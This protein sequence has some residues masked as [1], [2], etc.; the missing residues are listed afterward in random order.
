MVVLGDTIGVTGIRLTDPNAT[1]TMVWA[2]ESSLPDTPTGEEG[3]VWQI[4]VNGVPVDSGFQGQRSISQP[5]FSD[6]QS[7]LPASR[8]GMAP[9]ECYAKTL[10]AGDYGAGVVT[11]QA[12]AFAH[13]GVSVKAMRPIA[14][15]NDSDGTDRRPS[16]KTIHWRAQTGSNSN[17]GLSSGA[18]VKDL[19]KAIELACVS[20]NCGGATIVMHE[21]HLGGGGPVSPGPWHTGALHYLTIQCEPGTTWSRVAAPISTYPDDYVSCTGVGS[22]T[23]CR[24]RIQNYHVVGGGP[25]FA[26]NVNGSGLPDVVVQMWREGG[27]HGS[28]YYDT[29]VNALCALDDIEC[30]SISPHL[31]GNSTIHESICTGELRKGSRIAYSAETLI[32]DC[33]V[34]GTLGGATYIQGPFQNS[35]CHSIVA[36]E[37]TYR[38]N[39]TRGWACNQADGF[40][41]LD[42]LEIVQTGSTMRVLGPPGGSNAFGTAAQLLIDTDALIQIANHPNSA[43]NGQ[44]SVIDAG[45]TSTRQYVDLA[46]PSGVTTASTAGVRLETFLRGQVYNE[47]VHTSYISFGTGRT[48]KDTFRD[49][50]HYDIAEET[51][52]AF[53][54]LTSHD[55]VLIDNV[56]GAGGF[57][58]ISMGVGSLTNSIVRRCSWPASTFLANGAPFSWAGTQVT[59]CV[60]NTTGAGVPA[61]IAAGMKMDYCH[62]V[63]GSAP[64]GAL[65]HTTGPWLPSGADP[66]ESPFS[67][68]PDPSHYGNG[69]PVMSNLPDWAFTP[70]NSTKGATRAVAT[71]SWLAATDDIEG[72][73]AVTVSVTAS[74]TGFVGLEAAGAGTVTVQGAG[75]GFVGLQAVGAGVVQVFGAG[76]GF[77]GATAPTTVEPLDNELEREAIATFGVLVSPSD[78]T[79]LSEP[80]NGIRVTSA[81]NVSIHQ[82]DGTDVDILLP[83]G[84]EFPIRAV[85]VNL[86]NTTASGIYALY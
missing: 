32:Y 22:M 8:T 66:L 65:H 41:P 33:E 67:I 15:L 58:N 3:V 77:L 14:I 4:D 78:T 16:N 74:G 46:N 9:V 34:F 50:C 17:N 31:S 68:A 7:R 49:I 51:Q 20:N 25:V 47:L 71:I 13:D 43:N 55:S 70:S 84:V 28:A 23:F 57:S 59:N 38:R 1:Y 36:H 60:F 12:V 45:V 37:H 40:L 2:V 11:V 62:T 52:G 27:I 85:R 24:I 44:F 79:N 19:H 86:T 63:T 54:N 18:A 81:G 5:N 56:R 76:A 10:R 73:G 26:P 69:H 64:A 82:L 80:C 21:S 6:F 35:M 75:S 61:A 83:A 42:D 53:D 39:V 29:S 48:G 72:A 30:F